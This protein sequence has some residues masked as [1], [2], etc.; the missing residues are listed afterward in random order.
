MI[1]IIDKAKDVGVYSSLGS[2]ADEMLWRCYYTEDRATESTRSNQLFTHVETLLSSAISYMVEPVKIFERPSNRVEKIIEICGQQEFISGNNEKLVDYFT[3]LLAAT[4][5]LRD[6]TADE[7]DI[8]FLITSWDYVSN[9]TLALAYQ[10][11]D[12]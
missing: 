6:D 8:S 2:I 9:V 11:L 3:E 12:K 4:N 1:N 7:N 5:R 10:A